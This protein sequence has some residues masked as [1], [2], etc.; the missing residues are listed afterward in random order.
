MF[1]P[2][3]RTHARRDL[4]R[5]VVDGHTVL[6]GAMAG[7]SRLG[8]A[9]DAGA[10]ALRVREGFLRARLPLRFWRTESRSLSC[11]RQW[12]SGVGLSAALPIRTN[13]R[14]ES[15]RRVRPQQRSTQQRAM[16]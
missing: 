6:A 1:P 14:R 2:L 15:M 13:R 16:H 10:V 4:D 12:D 3:I 5:G 7:G 8:H 11:V 9:A